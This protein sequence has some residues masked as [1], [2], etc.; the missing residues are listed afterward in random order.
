MLSL[1]LPYVLIALLAIAVAVV[2]RKVTDRI[3]A[4]LQAIEAQQA[5]QFALLEGRIDEI[6]KTGFERAY[7]HDLRFDALTE[8]L[9]VLEPRQQ[10]DH[11]LN[12]LEISHRRGDLTPERARELEARFLAWRHEA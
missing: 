11:L 12:L 7:A 9:D 2:L 4:R 3:K 6:A 10:A 8:R 1:L 5:Q